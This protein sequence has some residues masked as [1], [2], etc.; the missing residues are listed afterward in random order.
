MNDLTHEAQPVLS[1]SGQ[2]IVFVRVVGFEDAAD[3]KSWSADFNSMGV[4]LFEDITS[5]ASVC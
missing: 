5:R 3:A 1:D 4:L 2:W